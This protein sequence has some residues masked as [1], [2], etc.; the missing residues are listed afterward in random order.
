MQL[1]DLVQ[2]QED[3]RDSNWES[4]FFHQLTQ[5]DV[6]VLSPEPQQGPDGWPYLMVQTKSENK[7]V[8]AESAQK[9]IQWLSERG[10]GLV[11]NPT[12]EYPDY[13]FTYGMLWHFRQTGLFYQTTASEIKS[14]PVEINRQS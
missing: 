6:E 7:T 1:T 9:I 4:L 13:V 12:K 3:K 2:T 14:G 10:I 5:S 11:V 8:P